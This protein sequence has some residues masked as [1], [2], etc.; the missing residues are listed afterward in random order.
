MGVLFIYLKRGERMPKQI[1]SMQ[2][3]FE[4]ISEQDELL[5]E[6]VLPRLEKVER[7][8]E[9]F[10]KVQEKFAEEFTKEISKIK[11]AQSS[12]ELT[13][14]KENQANRQQIDKLEGTLTSQND[15]LFEIVKTSLGM[16]SK[17]TTQD[18]EFKMAKWNH[19][20][21]VLLKIGGGITLLLG[22]GT[23]AV[24]IIEHYFGK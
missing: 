7:V 2:E 20:A 17:K 1:G 3:A 16:Q 21:N 8:Q 9:T 6:N 10:A 19:V 24:M 11:S 23:G 14:F 15:N 12:L 18:H 22:S 4:S 13:V 5:K